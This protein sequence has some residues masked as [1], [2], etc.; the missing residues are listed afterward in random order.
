MIDQDIIGQDDDVLTVYRD[1]V[2]DEDEPRNPM[3]G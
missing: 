2:V 3:P 1:E